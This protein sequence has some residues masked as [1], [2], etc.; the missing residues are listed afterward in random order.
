M[1]G[2]PPHD[3]Q[4]QVRTETPQF[5]SALETFKSIPYTDFLGMELQIAGN[6]VTG[7]LPYRDMLIGNS[8]IPALHGGVIGAFLEIT[9]AIQIIAVTP[10]SRLPKPVDISI[11]YLRSG[12]P[13][14]TF[15]RAI[16]SKQGRRVTNVRAEAWQE[17]RTRPIATL[18]GHFLVK[19]ADVDDSGG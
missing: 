3:I 13:Q 1:N 7:L 17:D 8:F 18:H 14:D 10:T 4:N 12:K 9:A 5:L 15:A 19:P 6:E 2:T 16:V 11:D